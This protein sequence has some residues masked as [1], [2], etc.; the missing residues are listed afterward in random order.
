MTII[1]SA[2][3][4][5]G[6][7]IAALIIVAFPVSLCIISF[8]YAGICI[9]CLRDVILSGFVLASENGYLPNGFLKKAGIFLFVIYVWGCTIAVNTMK[10]NS[11]F[12]KLPRIQNTRT[13]A[14]SC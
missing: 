11:G 13:S 1:D 8:S 4:V 9:C 2:L 10:W 12:E 5:A 7:S 14:K 6:I 3:M